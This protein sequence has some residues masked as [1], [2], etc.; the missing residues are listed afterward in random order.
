MFTGCNIGTTNSASL[1]EKETVKLI[2]NQTKF[3]FGIIS[4][5]GTIEDF[6]SNHTYFH[7]VY[8]L[9]TKPVETRLVEDSY[10]FG[11]VDMEELPRR[12]SYGACA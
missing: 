9:V 11:W 6:S 4:L 7:L 3:Y 10:L 12:I 5:I 2:L 1:N 8:Q